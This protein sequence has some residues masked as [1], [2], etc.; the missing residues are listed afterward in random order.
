MGCIP[1]VLCFG[2]PT[3]PARRVPHPGLSPPAEPPLFFFLPPSPP[4][5]KCPEGTCDGCTFHFLWVTGEG[6]PRCSAG[7]YR[8][9][10]GACLGGIQVRP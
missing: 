5:S 8:P 2:D 9:I 6:C 3:V 7:H 1:W 10:V 4:P